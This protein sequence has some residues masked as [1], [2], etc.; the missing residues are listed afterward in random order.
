MAVG[1]EVESRKLKEAMQRLGEIIDSQG[2]PSLGPKD[3][4]IDATISPQAATVEVIET[5]A[6]A[7]PFGVKA[8][9]PRW[10]MDRQRVAFCKVGEKHVG[11]TLEDKIGGRIKAV[12]FTKPDSP[13]RNALPS[14]RGKTAHF[15]GTL[16]IDNYKGRRKPMLKIEDVALPGLIEHQHDPSG[17][18]RTASGFRITHLRSR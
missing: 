17:G 15:A 7:G 4:R 10:A 6:R 9:Q 5:L 13:L 11:L 16:M 3:L 18:I 2:T 8:P 1:L 14:L 12:A